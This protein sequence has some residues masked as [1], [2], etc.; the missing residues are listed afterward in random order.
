[1]NL[2]ESLKKWGQEH[3]LNDLEVKET[4]KQDSIL[5]E[6]QSQDF[7]LLNKLFLQHSKAN[8]TSKN[9]SYSPLSFQLARDNSQYKMWEETGEVL[10][11]N[12]QV[13][14]FLL[15]GG[16]GSRLGFEGPKGA[17]DIGLESKKTLFQIQAERIDNL[18]RRFGA[19]IPWCIMTSP[20]NHQ[21]T[22]EHFT[23]NQHFGLDPNNIQ[24]FQQG[25]LCALDEKGKAIQ[26]KDGHLALVPDG[27]GGCFRA[28]AQSGNLDW[29]K[30]KGIRY[31]FMYGVDN[32]LTKIADPAF[33]GAL[34]TDGRAL[35]SSKVVHKKHLN[36][37]VGVFALH[38]NLPTVIEYIDIPEDLRNSLQDDGTPLFDGANI[39]TH[40]FKIE[41]LQ[42]LQNTPLPWHAARKHVL[43]EKN[44]WKFE[45][46]LFDAF[47]I[48]GSMTLYG[49]SRGEEF[50][51][52]KNASGEDSPASAKR[53][54]GLLH[55][56]WLEESNVKINP[57][58]LYEISP[59]L[60]YA[61]EGLNQRVFD[62]ELAKNILEF[63]ADFE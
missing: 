23:K 60:S 25:T 53:L 30:S 47:P 16:Q 38:N 21:E 58:M 33:I 43:E 7:E 42:K 5:K 9:S 54:L 22:I 31:V 32:L 1:M 48:L 45:Q 57:K 36:E 41:A 63:P 61:G 37:K 49:V 46:F 19:S 55:R 2:L 24:F 52:I 27:N 17:F 4:S 15:A 59:T 40:L 11:R 14:V 56:F 44:A 6:I 12:S 8:D 18:S 62:Q 10:L 26:D 29:L 39:A 51:P 13:A 34:A 3:L 35:S 28:I 20:L 50:A